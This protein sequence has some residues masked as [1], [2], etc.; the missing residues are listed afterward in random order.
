MWRKPNESAKPG[1]EPSAPNA[2]PAAPIATNIG[3]VGQSPAPV[4]HSA[5]P[6]SSSAHPATHAPVASHTD[7]RIPSGIKING[8]ISGNVDL[9]IDG[10]VKGSIRLPGARLTVGPQGNVEADLEAAEV[11]VEGVVTGNIKAADKA[12][13][14]PASRTKGSIAAPR[15]GIQEGARL[16]GK[17]DMTAPGKPATTT[18]PAPAQVPAISSA[19]TQPSTAPAESPVASPVSSTSP[20][21]D[22][23][24]ALAS[25]VQQR[26]S[27]TPVG[28]VSEK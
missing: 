4:T 24:S 13:F 11:F 17:V 9:F 18:S 22:K 26:Q 14:G 23:G 21:S 12:H 16:S 8:Q 28:A 15:I 27:K 3:E 20:A 6:Q 10:A 19:S 25:A 5:P 2:N 7:S 1:S